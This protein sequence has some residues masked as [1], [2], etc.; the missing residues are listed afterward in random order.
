MGSHLRYEPPTLGSHLQSRIP[1]LGFPFVRPV[2][3]PKHVADELE[4]L[5]LVLRRL[6]FHH[7]SI[8]DR[9][10]HGGDW[11]STDCGAEEFRRAGNSGARFDVSY[12]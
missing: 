4:G 5:S 7:F 3:I 8:S 12:W 10:C 1:L 6:K 9:C 11:T 2:A